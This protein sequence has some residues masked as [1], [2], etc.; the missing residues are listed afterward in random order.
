MKVWSK[1]EFHWSQGNLTL[2]ERKL[3]S[4]GVILQL[5][6]AVRQYTH[7]LV[8][9]LAI[10]AG[11]ELGHALL[12]KKDSCSFSAASYFTYVPCPMIAGEPISRITV[13]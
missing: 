1:E 12:T 11:L 4:R 10:Q 2:L 5:N 3:P 7:Y 6:L 9:R 8:S 13:F